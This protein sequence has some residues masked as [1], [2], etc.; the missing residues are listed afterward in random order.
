MPA[1]AN[2]ATLLGLL[3]ALAASWLIWRDARLASPGL[4]FAASV[5]PLVLWGFL[6]VF[7]GWYG[8][9][10]DA[11][12][13]TGRAMAVRDQKRAALAFLKNRGLSGFRARYRVPLFL[14]LGP[15]GS[16]KS[17]ILK[18]SD[19]QLGNGVRIGDAVWWAGKEGI[20]VEAPLGTGHETI[21]Q[22]TTLLAALRPDLPL[23][24]IL[25]VL[26]PADLALADSIEYESLTQATTESIREIE[27]RTRRRYPVYLL[28]SKVDLAPGFREFFDRHEPQERQQA[29][30]FGLPFEGLARPQGGEAGDKALTDGFRGILAALRLR[31]IEWLS[32]EGDPIRS[33]RIQSFGA[34]I[35]TISDTI[36]PMLEA[37][38]PD[39]RPD[40]KGAALRGVFLTS[41]RQEALAIDPLLPEMSLRFAMPRSGTVP[42]DL[43]LDEEEHG[44]F[45]SGALRKGAFQEAGLSLK[46]SPYHIRL[47]LQW[48]AAA[49]VVT[50]CIG[51]L[52]LASAIHDR[53]AA[54]PREAAAAAA[55]FTPVASPSQIGKTPAVLGDL[56]KL[57]A[58]NQRIQSA[59]EDKPRVPGFSARPKLGEALLRAR[60]AVL[61]NALAPHL[62][63]ILESQLVDM[64]TDAK[65]LQDLIRLA[66]RSAPS[67]EAAIRAWLEKSAEAVPAELRASFVADGLEAIK[68][69]GG[70]TAGASYIAAARRI[71]AY[72]E[73]LS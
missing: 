7:L 16:G 69:A 39:D 59:S 27:R 34:Q 14:V 62:D 63:A 42:P 6:P 31:L 41:A 72:K 71:I 60:R 19:L 56:R 8:R 28:L 5:A 33:G 55:T 36:R 43:G 61:Q 47:L 18:Q 64:D 50:A 52:V 24:G 12:G 25:L 2:I 4:H 11:R 10:R 53:E 54:W 9:R 57:A 66:D 38:F 65:T 35:A 29:W 67:E 15:G 21:L 22:L 30:G 17:S 51:F 58:L 20:F 44:F 23:N 45:I 3:V 49:C 32:R 70:M 48:L 1:R 37:L 68:A 46:E 26:A 40:W 13:D 73:S